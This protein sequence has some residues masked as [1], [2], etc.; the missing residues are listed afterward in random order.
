MLV[1][2]TIG[3]STTATAT[4]NSHSHKRTCHSNLCGCYYSK[5]FNISRLLLFHCF[6]D[7]FALWVTLNWYVIIVSEPNNISNPSDNN[8]R[9]CEII[10]LL[11]LMLDM[12][13]VNNA[14]YHNAITHF[15]IE[16][17]INTTSSFFIRTL[18]NFNCVNYRNYVPFTQWVESLFALIRHAWLAWYQLIV[19]T[20][21][22]IIKIV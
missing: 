10:I 21:K 12:R 8:R 5:R 3:V 1:I 11:S 14:D 7:A 13:K 17:I 18:A 6:V 22:V 15:L 19:C 4:T 20:I 2:Y 16:A 9:A